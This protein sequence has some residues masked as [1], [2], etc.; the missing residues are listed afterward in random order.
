MTPSLSSQ[1]GLFVEMNK[2]NLTMF[3]YFFMHQVIKDIDCLSKAT[4]VLLLVKLV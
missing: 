4:K 1:F 2:I 3:S